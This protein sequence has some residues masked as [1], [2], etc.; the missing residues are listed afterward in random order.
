[1]RPD[2]SRH[3]HILWALCVL[4]PCHS[5]LWPSCGWRRRWQI[6]VGVSGEGQVVGGQEHP[7]SQASQVWSSLMF[8]LLSIFSFSTHHPLIFY[9]FAFVHNHR[10]GSCLITHRT[11]TDPPLIIQATQS[12]F[13]LESLCHR[14]ETLPPLEIPLTWSP[15]D[16]NFCH[17]RGKKC[18]SKSSESESENGV[19]WMSLTHFAFPQVSWLSECSSPPCWTPENSGRPSITTAAPWAWNTASASAATPTTSAPFATNSAEPETTFSVTLTAT[20]AAPR[21]AWRDG[22]DRSAKKVTDTTC[23][24]NIQ[25]HV[26]FVGLFWNN[27]HSIITW[28][29]T[30]SF[31]VK[32]RHLQSCRC[33]V[34]R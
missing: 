3:T 31:W 21:F 4:I 7:H 25:V 15:Q 2:T 20:R 34:A 13:S 19:N 6:P 33:S 26:L 23:W 11:H 22:R 10:L 27:F 24:I 5:R 12:K 16:S 8:A 17:P 32:S 28:Q 9:C 30:I 14:T 1:M 18:Q 29:I